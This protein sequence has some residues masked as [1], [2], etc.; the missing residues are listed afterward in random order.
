MGRPPKGKTWMSTIEIKNVTKAF[1]KTIALKNV[2]ATIADGKICGFLGRNGAGKTTLLNIITN[3]LFADQGQVLIDGEPALENDRAQAKL[4]LMTEKTLYPDDHKV[5]DVFQITR[6][7]YPQF[8]LDYAAALADRF[9][10]ETKKRIGALSTG[11][12]SIFKMILTLASNAPVLIFDEPVLGLDA[13]HRDLF[14][15]ELIALYNTTPKTVLLSTHLIE[16]AAGLLEEVII[17]KEGQVLLTQPVEDLLQLAYTVSGSQEAVDSYAA[18][19]KVIREEVLGRFKASTIYQKR[20]STDKETLTQLGLDLTPAR[21][22]EL[23]ISLT[24]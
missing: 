12:L 14:Y 18:G 10:L 5:Q 7:F 3:R 19:K 6:G 17:L 9:K 4:F 16:E 11:Y 20:S 21:L 22:Q 2:S 15:K 24:N 8:D 1:G 23:F 13:N